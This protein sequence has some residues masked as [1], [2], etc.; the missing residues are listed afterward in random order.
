[1]NVG[2]G[3]WE[4]LLILIIVLI[5]CGPGKR[6]D[7]AQQMGK[8][9]RQIKNFTQELKTELTKEIDSTEAKEKKGETTKDTP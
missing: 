5:A 3:F 2:I 7:I 1:V 6:V 9:V 8:A 4:V